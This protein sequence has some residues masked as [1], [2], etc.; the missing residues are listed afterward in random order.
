LL[1]TELRQGEKAK[2]KDLSGVNQFMKRRLLDLGIVEG[3]E[4]HYKYT[5]PFG[6]PLILDC[7]GQS[8]GLRRM[9]AAS[10][11]VERL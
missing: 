9:E 5:L 10:I 4:I 2:I 3:S 6:G 11:Q 1:L 7:S 8:I